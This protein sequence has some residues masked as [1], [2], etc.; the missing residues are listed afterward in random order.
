MIYIIE[1]SFLFKVW[2]RWEV[3]ILASH[4]KLFDLDILRVH[5]DS[6]ILIQ[7]DCQSRPTKAYIFSNLFCV[8]DILLCLPSSVQ[9]NAEW[10]SKYPSVSAW[11]MSVLGWDTLFRVQKYIVECVAHSGFPVE[12]Q[13]VLGPYRLSLS[14]GKA[15]CYCIS[16][17]PPFLP[18]LQALL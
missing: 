7:P 10:K 5:V 4:L 1:F 15:L 8:Y 12:D 6:W 11:E 17:L 3:L 9:L 14:G 13:D 16:F 2:F 18:L